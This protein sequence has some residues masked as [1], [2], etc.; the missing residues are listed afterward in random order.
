MKRMQAKLEELRQYDGILVPGGFGS[1]GVEGIISAIK[2][3]RENKI[4]Y[5]GLCYG[6]QLMVIEYARNVANIPDAHTAE[7]KPEAQ[8]T[9]IDIMPE[10]KEKMARGDYGGT[11][12]LGGY[13]C[14]LVEGTIARE[15]YG[16]D[17]IRERHR[18]RYEVNPNVITKLSEAGL[19][20]SGVSPDEKLMEIAELP[21]EKHPFMLGTQFHPEFLSRPLVTTSFILRIYQECGNKK[22]LESRFL[23]AVYVYHFYSSLSS[24][25]QSFKF[26]SKSYG[27]RY[28]CV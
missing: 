19:K 23:F 21:R 12:R 14:K 4:P 22:R 25:E 28:C 7:I 10:Q 24:I 8:N 11:M 13:P 16:K 1:R 2:F 17:E 9:V 15:A 5:F 20:F 6:M 27:T 26:S 3:A 18:H